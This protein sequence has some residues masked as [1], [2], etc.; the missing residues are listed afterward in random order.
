MSQGDC[1]DFTSRLFL[2]ILIASQKNTHRLSG[3]FEVFSEII[4]SLINLKRQEAR[5]LWIPKFQSWI[6]ILIALLF[7][8]GLPILA[9]DLFP[10]FL[11]L[12]R[13]DLFCSGLAVLC[14]G[15]LLLYW[16][17]LQPSRNLT[18]LLNNTFFFYFMSVYIETGLDSATSWSQ[19][20]RAVDFPKFLKHKLDRKELQAESLE[21]H[22][23]DLQN[24]LPAPWP[25]I[26]NGLLW[27]KISGIGISKYLQKVSKSEA[28]RLTGL[29]QDQIQKLSMLSLIPL[30]LFIFPSTLFLLVGPLI[31]EIQNL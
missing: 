27:A 7:V 28:N 19:A 10:T 31:L 16:M 13:E 21:D 11:S 9:P 20:V 1:K 23:A 22:W 6:S 17:A 29:W 14:S 18:P 2:E 26:L 25:E 30:S 3:I 5:A 4:E 12:D 8:A 24:E 15:F